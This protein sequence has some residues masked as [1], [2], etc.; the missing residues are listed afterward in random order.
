[1]DSPR[2]LISGGAGFVGSHLVER[3]V[4]AGYQVDVVDN[5]ATGFQQN[6]EPLLDQGTVRLFV[7]DAEAFE[8]PE[9]SYR[10]VLHLAS[11][12][13]PVDFGPRALEILRVNSQGT[14]NLLEIARR[15]GARFLFAS[16]S[17]VYGDPE[18]H[19]QTEEYRGHVD[20]LGPRGPYDEG[21]RFGEAATMTYHRN[22]GLD[23]RIVRIFNTYGPRMRLDDGRVVPNFL[24]SLLEGRPLPVYGDGRQTRS[25]CYVTDLVEGLFRFTLLE[26]PRWRVINLGNPQEITI[27]ELAEILQEVTGRRVGVAFHPLPP[28]D[29]RRR[30]PD[31]RRAR[32]LLHWT[33]RVPLEEG[34]R[35]TWEWA[36]ATV[37]GEE[38]H[39]N[40]IP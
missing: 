36:L 4:Q 14:L 3:F 34:L 12:A 8:P 10:F 37:K 1:M 31:I 17:E 29:P 21:K 38:T 28:Q 2:V 35:R 9:T 39:G 19:P 40:G 23:V 27:L 33:P 5:L 26:A 25:F 20:P 24:R 13:S 16:T 11:P 18:V 15:Q 30:Q 32:T 6:L 7:A 22:F